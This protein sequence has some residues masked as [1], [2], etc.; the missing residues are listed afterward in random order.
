[1]DAIIKEDIVRCQKSGTLYFISQFRL[2]DDPLFPEG[3]EYIYC[4]KCKRELFG[5]VSYLYGK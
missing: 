4:D 5:K 2:E 3:F 1:M